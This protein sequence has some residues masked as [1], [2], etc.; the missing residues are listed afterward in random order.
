MSETMAFFSRLV[1]WTMRILIGVLAVIGAAGVVAH[2]LVGFLQQA[3]SSL[4]RDDTTVIGSIVS[5]D[6]EY[7]AIIFNQ[8]GGG[9]LSPYCIDYVSVVP[10]KIADKQAWGD[11]YSV[12]VASCGSLTDGHERDDVKWLSGK[13]LQITFDADI[14]VKGVS[15]MT[16]KGYADRGAISVSYLQKSY[17]HKVN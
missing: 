15:A 8:D 9:G 2:G 10:E 16:L 12:F 4:I 3:P 5:P 1:R 11:N 17:I 7:K 14:G 13:E 6:H